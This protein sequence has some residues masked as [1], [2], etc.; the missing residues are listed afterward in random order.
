MVTPNVQTSIIGLWVRP[1]QEAVNRAQYLTVCNG[2][3]SISYSPIGR[4]AAVIHRSYVS[5]AQVCRTRSILSQH[6]SVLSAPALMTPACAD[7]RVEIPKALTPGYIPT[8]HS[9][10]WPW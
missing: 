7:R 8:C 9:E 6:L 1:L 10:S 3:L 4:Y 5:A 2:K